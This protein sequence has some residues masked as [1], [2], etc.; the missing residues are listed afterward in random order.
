VSPSITSQPVGLTKVQGESATFTVVADGQAPLSYLWS[1]N[2]SPL[3][4]DGHVNGAL[5]ATL[6]LNNVQDADAATYAVQVSNAA[7]ASNSVPVTLTV[8]DYAVITVPPAPRTNNAGSDAFFDV[9][10]TGTPPITYQWYRGATPLTDDGLH[11]AGATTASL[12]ITNVQDADA[13]NGDYTVAVTNVVNGLVS[14]PATLTVWDQPEIRSG[15]DSR[16]NDACTVATFTVTVVG[17][18]PFSYQWQRDG[19]NV[20]GAN[21]SGETTDTL[22][23]S[24][25]LKADEGGYSVI[26]TNIPGQD[27]SSNAVLTVIDPVITTQPV[28]LYAPVGGEAVFSVVACGTTPFSYQWKKDGS[29]LTDGGSFSGTTT[30]TLTISPVPATDPI[31]TV[32]VSNAVGTATSED[33][34]L[35]VY[36]MADVVY[37]NTTNRSTPARFAQ[38]DGL[39]FGDE[40]NLAASGT[41][42]LTNFVFEYYGLGFGG[43]ETLSLRIYRNDGVSYGTNFSAPGTLL[44]DSGAVAIGAT[45]GATLSFDLNLPVPTNITWTVQFDGIGAGESAGLSLFDPP[46]VGSSAADYWERQ[47]D[48]S[49]L[50]RSRGVPPPVNFGARALA[51]PVVT[52]P[53]VPTVAIL[54]PTAYQVFETNVVTVSGTTT[55][56][57]KPSNVAL[58]LWKLGNGTYAPA[59][60][61]AT[62]SVDV[63]VATPGTNVVTVK[64]IDTAGNESPAVSR[65]FIYGVPQQLLVNIVDPAGGT[66]A[67][68]LNSNMLYVNV[69][70]TMTATPVANWL[71]SNWV[72]SV[73]G[74]VTND[75]RTPALSKSPVTTKSVYT[76]QMS[77]GLVLQA[78]F[79]TNLFIGAAGIYNGLYNDTNGVAFESAGFMTLKTDSKLKYSGKFYGRQEGVVQGCV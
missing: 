43:G 64:A 14:D 3:S 55:D 47:G 70:Y 2:T 57:T 15:P 27:V 24:S 34:V 66:L 29:D 42:L 13:T 51:A 22:T 62:W 50:L 12:I 18:P 20:S 72:N 65:S 21:I 26:V 25:L 32:V 48:G 9:T 63:T 16:T 36:N 35:T 73:S 6:S 69:S 30:D 71:F 38:S 23:V 61:T 54:T 78:N 52:D 44:Y 41:R 10:V 8:N 19:T 33:A 56:K 40:I 4:D 37:D 77:T 68:D 11:I 53:K 60:G 31:I 79:V 59:S 45:A 17:T 75:V 5:T 49:W 46:A 1:K 76:F 7:G 39:E 67:P 74:A 28:S 58:V